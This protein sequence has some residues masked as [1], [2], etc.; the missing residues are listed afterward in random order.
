MFDVG[1]TTQPLDLLH[2][3]APHWLTV[4]VRNAAARDLLSVSDYARLALLDRLRARGIDPA[5]EQSTKGG[6]HVDHAI[7][8]GQL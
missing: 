2:I 3:R 5:I 6:P 8:S 1:V 4:A 7:S